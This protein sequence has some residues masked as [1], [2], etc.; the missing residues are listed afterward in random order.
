[1]DL[2]LPQL[3]LDVGTFASF[4]SAAVGPLANGDFYF[5][6]HGT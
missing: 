4:G 3:L 1:M 2:L 6:S 5:N